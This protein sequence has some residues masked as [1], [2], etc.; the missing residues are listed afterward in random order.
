MIDLGQYQQ[1][2]F[3]GIEFHVTKSRRRSQHRIDKK[4]YPFAKRGR[5]TDMGVD[6]FAFEMEI[7]L[8]GNDA[9][10]RRAALEA[11]FDQIGPGPLVHPT[12]G[13]IS[14]VVE[15]VYDDEVFTELGVA[16]FNVTFVQAGD[17]TGPVARIDT[18]ANLLI[19]S[20]AAQKSTTAAYNLD[21]ATA[22]DPSKIDYSKALKAS[23]KLFQYAKNVTPAALKASAISMG[24]DIAIK[25]ASVGTPAL[26]NGAFGVSGDLATYFG[27]SPEGVSSFVGTL[28]ENSGKVWAAAQDNVGALSSVGVSPQIS[29]LS[30]RFFA[31]TSASNSS[32]AMNAASVGQAFY[33]ATAIT[34]ARSV[35]V[36]QFD[37]L[38]QALGVRDTLTQ[39]LSSAASVTTTDDPM[40]NAARSQSLRNL[41]TAVSRDI[42]ER[43]TGLPW[44]ASE[45]PQA[46]AP[47]R[48]TAYRL[49]GSLDQQIATL[50]G[51]RHAS[52]V[53]AAKPVLYLKDGA[54]E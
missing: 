14:V 29:S 16:D 39:A 15:S 24:E 42:S 19:A 26:M 46:D 32:E 11:A 43:S 13:T 38:Q 4:H 22:D 35:A 48:V 41:R 34:A 7:Y 6:D 2:S 49:T 44:L 36:T 45:T 27:A 54:N 5:V 40:K 23:I 12:R 33:D 18:Q 47:A 1:A 3:R 21:I 52:F 50:N 31:A 53:P 28:K 37:N 51:I 20:D 8:L 10:Q 9:L 17:A 25:M 30:Q